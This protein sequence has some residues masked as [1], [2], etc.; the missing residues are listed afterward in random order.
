[1]PR[2]GREG[3]LEAAG[4]RTPARTKTG[5][6]CS[7]DTGWRS[8][9][10]RSTSSSASKV[11]GLGLQCVGHDAGHSGTSETGEA[12]GTAAAS[13]G[14]RRPR[15]RR[16]RA[17]GAWLGTD[18]START[19]SAREAASAAT[20][21]P[22]YASSSAA[23]P[24]AGRRNPQRKTAHGSEERFF[25]HTFITGIRAKRSQCRRKSRPFARCTV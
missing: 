18:R 12:G 7:V 14:R 22:P 23:G 17:G 9:F 15:R 5:T 11:R 21:A 3:E 6:V 1:M 13:L 2:A 24:R 4:E 8:S 10:S 19:A 20:M 16:G 25:P